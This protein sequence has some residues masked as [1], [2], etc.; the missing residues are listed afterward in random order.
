MGEFQFET[1]P[2]NAKVSVFYDVKND[3][4]LNTTFD[5]ALLLKTNMHFYT[6]GQL[7]V[8]F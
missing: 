8:S 3:F 6:L 7:A 5:H 1:A 2:T 4:L